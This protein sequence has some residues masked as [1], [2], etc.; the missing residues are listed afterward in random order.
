MILYAFLLTLSII[1][2]AETAYLIKKRKDQKKPV[3]LFGE[4]CQKVLESKY[5]KTLGIYNDALGL[6]FYIAVFIISVFLITGVGPQEFWR[7]L[8]R[9]MIFGGILASS[10]FTYIQWRVIKE[11][12]FWCLASATTTFL[13]TVFVLFI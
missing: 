10:Y 8:I 6:L 2:I 5:N 4:D 12:C 1:G 7:I 11:W 13:M 3:C 9:T